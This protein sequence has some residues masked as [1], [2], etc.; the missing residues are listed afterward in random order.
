MKTNLGLLVLRVTF[1]LTMLIAHGWP[2]LVNFGGLKD[3]FRDPIGVGMTTSLTLAV[4]SE[5]FCALFIVLGL[6]TRLASIP[7]IATMIVAAFM[8]HGDDPWARKELAVV[9]LFA[10]TALLGTGAGGYSLDGLLRK[11]RF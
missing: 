4:F 3:S 10:F 7:L 1:G 11:D 9:Y 6:F 2:K 5:V 8:V